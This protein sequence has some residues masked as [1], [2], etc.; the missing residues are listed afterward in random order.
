MKWIQD[1]S[2]VSISIANHVYNLAQ[3]N[4]SIYSLQFE[5]DRYATVFTNINT[6]VRCFLIIMVIGAWQ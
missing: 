4:K 1:F 2:L 3:N 5:L 6:V